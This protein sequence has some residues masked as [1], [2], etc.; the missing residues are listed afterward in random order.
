MTFKPPFSRLFKINYYI[1]TVSSSSKYNSIFLIFYTLSEFDIGEANDE[2]I[3]LGL[4]ASTYTHHVDS[5][6]MEI[7]NM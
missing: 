2:T 1:F 3:S 7:Q 5:L 6:E 4:P